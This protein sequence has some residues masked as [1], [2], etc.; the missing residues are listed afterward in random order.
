M[1][2][3]GWRWGALLA[4]ALIA[5]VGLPAGGAERR[6]SEVRRRNA[7]EPL[8]TGDDVSLHAAPHCSA[9]VLGTLSSDEPLRV[10]RRWSSAGGTVW[11]QVQARMPAG[12]ASRGW[13]PL[14][15]QG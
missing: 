1:P 5:P 7:P 2:P 15:A 8:I 3:L 12:C 9:P 11:L 10:L 14:R 13:M 4:F 6:H